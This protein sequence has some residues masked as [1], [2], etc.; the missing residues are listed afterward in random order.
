M[1]DAEREAGYKLEKSILSTEEQRRPSLKKLETKTAEVKALEAKT[2][3]GILLIL[4][5]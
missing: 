5:A 4:H 1:S 3:T 2:P